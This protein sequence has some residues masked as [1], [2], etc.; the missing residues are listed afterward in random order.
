MIILNIQVRDL[1]T[2]IDFVQQILKGC[3]DLE[4]KKNVSIIGFM[5][6]GKSTIGKALAD[7]LSYKFVDTDE[8]IEKKEGRSIKNMF[9][10]GGEGY[11]RDAES[12]MVEEVCA[13]EGLVVSTGGG[14]ILRSRNVDVLRKSSTVVWLRANRETILE[15]L[16][17]SA[18][19]R[20]LMKKGEQEAKV[21]KMLFERAPK[22]E[23]AAH[24]IMDVDGKSVEDIV[25]EILFNLGKI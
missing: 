18:D 9:E 16:R 21:D 24:F 12:R 1:N 4:N 22:Y 25:V 13:M 15:N 17:R 11:F 8:L 23:N 5:A 3:Y 7:R 10:T 19:V 14:A 20:P 6:S 2:G